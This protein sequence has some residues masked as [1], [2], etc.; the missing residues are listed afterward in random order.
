MV[1]D[2]KLLH[3]CG[4]S[5]SLWAWH[6]L[7]GCFILPSKGYKSSPCLHQHCSLTLCHQ[8][9]ECLSKGLL[10]RR[11]FL[12]KYCRPCTSFTGS[13]WFRDKPL[14]YCIQFQIL[15][16]YLRNLFRCLH[17]RIWIPENF[18]VLFLMWCSDFKRNH[19]KWNRSSKKRLTILPICWTSSVCWGVPDVKLGEYLGGFCFW[20][21]RGKF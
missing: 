1:T 12:L 19:S 7:W 5:T 10:K 3:F 2:W 21:W 20:R 13:C 15:S 4:W 18:V 11:S 9:R 16:P 8:H 14:S 6:T 17:H